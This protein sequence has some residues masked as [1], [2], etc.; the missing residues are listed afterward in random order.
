MAD[1]SSKNCDMSLSC[2]VGGGAGSGPASI[3]GGPPD[4]DGLRG[5]SKP[6][7]T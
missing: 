2:S 7:K 5:A 6:C 4:C 1:T 3:S